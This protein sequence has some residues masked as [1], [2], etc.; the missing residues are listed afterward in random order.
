MDER[1]GEIVF[2]FHSAPRNCSDSLFRTRAKTL[3]RI[4]GHD[5][6]CV[7]EGRQDGE[8][9][10][11]LKKIFKT[12]G[13]SLSE[14]SRCKDAIY[15]FLQ[16]VWGLK[17]LEILITGWFSLRLVPFTVYVDLISATR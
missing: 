11:G 3:F 9:L 14:L 16:L 8:K 17:L 1:E 10:P 4:P 5:K 12:Q 15:R 6:V 13:K 7:E 2:V